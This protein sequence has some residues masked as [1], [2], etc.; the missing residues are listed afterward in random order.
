MNAFLDGLA[1]VLLDNP[2]F[3]RETRGWR[4]W[5]RRSRPSAWTAATVAAVLGWLYVRILWSMADV[6]VPSFRPLWFW[7]TRGLL[8]FVVV[9][10][11][12]LASA[13]ITR[14]REQRTW[15][16]LTLTRL[17]GHEVILGKWL[18]ALTPALL[19]V[20]ATAPLLLLVAVGLGMSLALLV[21]M[22]AFYLLT[23]AAFTM[24]GLL[25]SFVARHASSARTAVLTTTFASCFGLIIVD[26]ILRVLALPWV[27]SGTPWGVLS[28]DG[29]G[30]P[31]QDDYGYHGLPAVSWFSPLYVLSVLSNRMSAGAASSAAPRWQVSEE[32]ADV[33]SADPSH[34]LLVYDLGLVIG[35]ALCLYYMLTRYRRDVRGGRPLGEPIA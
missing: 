6:G 1:R 2:V 18:S 4:R 25:C 19:T 15:E 13:S 24:L 34:V 35:I 9:V 28:P 26:G 30:G 32:D 22:L 16:S 31:L 29:Y 33:W 12:I 10:A 8:L 5:L 17:P 27:H 3:R 21:V 7:L 14:E 23:A 11:P 20:L